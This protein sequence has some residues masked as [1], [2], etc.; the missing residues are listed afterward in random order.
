MRDVSKDPKRFHQAVC[1]FVKQAK[2]YAAPFTMISQAEAVKVAL[3]LSDTALGITR[4]APGETCD[5][6]D[7]LV[8]ASVPENAV[9]FGGVKT[10][11]TALFQQT[12]QKLGAA[13]M[14]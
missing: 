3:Y 13:I 12:G 10:M 14:L 11:D 6:S 7:K 8:V 9:G 5:L 2:S 4:L 1:G